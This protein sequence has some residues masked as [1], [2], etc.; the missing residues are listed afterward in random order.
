MNDQTSLFDLGDA[1][2]DELAR[3]SADGATWTEPSLFQQGRTSTPAELASDT[4]AGPRLGFGTM[5]QEAELGD[6]FGDP[7]EELEV[8]E[9]PE[10]DDIASGEVW[11]EDE[12]ELGP[13]PFGPPCT[14]AAHHEL[15]RIQA[16]DRAAE[17]RRRWRRESTRGMDP[18]LFC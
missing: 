11:P 18:G 6:M 15:A 7:E 12:G 8:P 16:A 13:C 5:S 2:G 10:R 4:V 14:N 9:Y 1:A 17:E 3:T